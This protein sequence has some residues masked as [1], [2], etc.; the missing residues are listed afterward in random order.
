MKFCVF[1]N[2]HSK[3]LPVQSQL[4]SKNTDFSLLF[5]QNFVFKSISMKKHKHKV[6]R[7]S[8]GLLRIEFFHIS[9]NFGISFYKISFCLLYKFWGHV[10]TR[11]NYDSKCL[12][13]AH[14][15]LMK[16]DHFFKMTELLLKIMI[17]IILLVSYTLVTLTWIIIFQYIKTTIFLLKKKLPKMAYQWT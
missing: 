1:P 13:L 14:I 15:G 10:K 12:N 5:N 16:V 3:L 4:R 6:P 9:D 11:L 17:S 7:L 2:F 8:Y